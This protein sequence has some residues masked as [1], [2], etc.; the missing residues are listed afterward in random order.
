MLYLH[1]KLLRKPKDSLCGSTLKEIAQECIRLRNV[2]SAQ[3]L[4]SKVFKIFFVSKITHSFLFHLHF[5]FRQNGMSYGNILV[6]YLGTKQN[7]WQN[8]TTVLYSE[9]ISHFYSFIHLLIRGFMW[10]S[11]LY[12]WEHFDCKRL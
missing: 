4:Y 6:F 2:F 9:I 10:L 5:S 7:F 1:T 12:T 3:Y 8:K 11:N